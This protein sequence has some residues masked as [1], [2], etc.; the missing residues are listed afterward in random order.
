MK[1]KKS[2]IAEFEQSELWARVD[3][4]GNLLSEPKE[5]NVLVKNIS[6]NGFAITYLSDLVRMIDTIGGKKM[7]VVKYI[8]SH[9]DSNNKLSETQR[10]IAKHCGVSLKTVTETLN[11]L[12]K[13]NFIARKTGTIMLS[14][15][16]AHKGNKQ[17]ERYLLMKFNNIAFGDPADNKI[18]EQ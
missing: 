15:K 11:M 9:M 3:P 2:K 12:D 1:E 13:A 14:P 7:T 4:D 5:V 16:I 8:L 10:E 6:R 17:R 18:G